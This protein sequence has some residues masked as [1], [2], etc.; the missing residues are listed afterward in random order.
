MA[1]EVLGKAIV[2]WLGLMVLAVANGAVR[3]AILTRR[4]GPG[5]AHVV[6]TVMLCAIIVVMTLVSGTWIGISTATTGLQ[7]GLGW[8]VLTLSFEF[9]AG[10]YVFGNSWEKVLADYNLLKG[11][12]WVFVP[13][14]TVAA[15]WIA[16]LRR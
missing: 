7:V 12:V 16:G 1:M 15:P 8:L 10:H 11:R 9:L 5:A 13:L 3:E 2:V 14:T 6:S 4:I